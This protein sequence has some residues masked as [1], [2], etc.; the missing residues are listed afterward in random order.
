M[1]AAAALALLLLVAGAAHA[2]SPQ[3]LLEGTAVAVSVSGAGTQLQGPLGV[4]HVLGT[5]SDGVAFEVTGTIRMEVDFQDSDG[6]AVTFVRGESGTEHPPGRFTAAAGHA[7]RE[8][9]EIVVFPVTGR[10]A[11]VTAGPSTVGVATPSSVSLHHVDEVPRQPESVLAQGLRVSGSGLEVRGTFGIAL[12]EWDFEATREDGSTAPFWTG[13]REDPVPPLPQG[14][15]DVVRKSREQQAF[16]FVTDGVLTLPGAVLPVAYMPSALA[17]VDGALTLQGVH[18]DMTASPV[19]QQV[20]ADRFSIRGDLQV[21]LREP[22]NGRVPFVATGEGRPVIE[23]DGATLQWTGPSG[24]WGSW[25]AWAT[26]AGVTAL[27]LLAPPAAVGARRGYLDWE[28]RRLARA[29]SLL[30]VEAYPAA[31]RAVRPLLR[32]ARLRSEAVV[33]HVE[34]L[35]AEGRAAEALP[36]LGQDRFWTLAPALRD[37][38]VARAHAVLGNVEDARAALARAVAAAPDL[39]AQAAAEPSLRPLIHETPEGYT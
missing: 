39:H 2:G 24:G 6:Y 18:A 11:Q 33:I 27:A 10:A 15:Q 3:R 26:W 29:E 35:L 21:E 36:V 34:S 19:A 38:L 20:S 37:Y 9:R 8:N 12:W 16:L 28:S 5:Q 13:M 4:V 23:V 32:S 7:G 1:K 14:T 30:E 31:R 22:A 25:P 17:D